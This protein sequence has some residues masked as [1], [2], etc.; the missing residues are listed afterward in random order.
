MVWRVEKT[1]NAR[2]RQA[3]TWIRSENMFVRKMRMQ[4]HVSAA[5]TEQRHDRAQVL[6][7]ESCTQ[8]SEGYAEGSCNRP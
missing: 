7:S 6:S 2:K 4:T 8:P 5:T 1:V 3:V